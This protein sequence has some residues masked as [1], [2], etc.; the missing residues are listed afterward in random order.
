M[1]L[2]LHIESAT[3]ICSVALSSEGV[4]LNYNEEYSEQYIHSE[5]LTILIEQ[6]VKEA[7]KNLSDL[8]AI[9]IDKG[10]G[11]F[12]G[13]RIGVSVAKGL[14]YSLKIPLTSIDSRTSLF[15]GFKNSTIKTSNNDVIL[16]MID[17]RRMEVYTSGFKNNGEVIFPVGA[18]NVD[19]MFFEKLRRFDKV[20]IFGDGAK[21]VM[22]SFNNDQLIYH[23]EIVCSSKHQISQSYTKFCD[24]V[25]EDVA[26]FEPYYLK[27][28]K[29]H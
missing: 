14:C 29:P 26:Y 2:Q 22:A 1:S 3:K 21:K 19:E 20:H 24:K 16:P 7:G 18:T 25:F 5:R 11:S 28:F 4:L 9:S 15:Y 23:P 12:T 6:T 10:P 17:A 8:C 27:D 13:L